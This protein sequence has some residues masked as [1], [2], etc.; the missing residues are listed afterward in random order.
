MHGV[1]FLLWQWLQKNFTTTEKVCVIN[2]WSRF[3]N[4][5]TINFKKLKWLPSYDDA[6]INKCVL[7]YKA[8]QGESPMY[9]RDL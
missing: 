6:K 1:D 9:V 2:S 5:N 3:K 8:F 4:E 7:I